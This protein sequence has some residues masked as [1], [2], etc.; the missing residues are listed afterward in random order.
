[1]RKPVKFWTVKR[2]INYSDGARAYCVREVVKAGKLFCFASAV[3]IVINIDIKVYAQMWH[4]VLWYLA[5]NHSASCSYLSWS[6]NVTAS[7]SLLSNT[8]HNTTYLQRNIKA[9]SWIHRCRGKAESIT[10]SECAFQ[11]LSI[12]HS[13]RMRHIFISG[14][15][16]STIFFQIV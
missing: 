9:R 1:V 10:Y 3:I 12:Q 7:K 5:R 16:R 4:R 15:P 11:D 8:Q 6:I 14:L 2:R 13:M